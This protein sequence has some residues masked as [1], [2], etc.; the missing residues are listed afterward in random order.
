MTGR[1]C[2]A[3]NFRA[4]RAKDGDIRKYFMRV[5]NIRNRHVCRAGNDGERV[6]FFAY[7]LFLGRYDSDF[8]RNKSQDAFLGNSD[9]S[10]YRIAD[11][12]NYLPFRNFQVIRS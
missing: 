11:R 8:L 3:I 6:L 2:S 5:F 7:H 12:L 4:Y 10:F 1:L 9:R